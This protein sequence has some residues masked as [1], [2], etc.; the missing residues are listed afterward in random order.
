MKAC[1]L[2]FGSI[3]IFLLGISV[4]TLAQENG[5][6]LGY[7]DDQ[8][9]AY[10]GTYL[11]ERGGNLIAAAQVLA[12]SI[13]ELLTE[14][15]SAVDSEDV[16]N[17][18]SVV[19]PGRWFVNWGSDSATCPDGNTAA[20]LN[21]SFLLTLT[22]EG[23]TATDNY[24]WPPL[25]FTPTD[26]EGVYSFDRNDSNGAFTYRYEVK[27]LSKE[28]MSGS[29]KLF[30]QNGCALESSFVMYL[31]D[32]DTICMVNSENGANL[33]SGP[34]TEFSRA[35]QLPSVQLQSVI[36][37]AT[38]SDGF[39]WWQLEEENWV[40]SDVVEEIGDCDSVREIDS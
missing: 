23:F 20:A 13:S 6:S 18:D 25:E 21:R 38:G 12:D 4:P 22:D 7:I 16:S 14:C 34:G 3:I 31:Q 11:I 26:A 33:R 40:R 15:E 36:G 1:V 39:V 29:I 5:C 9:D 28:E 35:G 2:I 17:T 8:I 32:A 27:I 19:I 10:Y 37:R 24:V 30:F